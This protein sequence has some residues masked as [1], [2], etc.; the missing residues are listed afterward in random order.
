MAGAGAASTAPVR[1]VDPNG[2]PILH[3]GDLVTITFQDLVIPLAPIETQVKDDGTI[4]LIYNQQF[5]AEGKT[6]GQLEKEIYKT[7]VPAYFK[8][9]TPIVKTADHFF[10]VGGE[11]KSPGRQVYSG[12]MTVLGA[13]DTAGGFTDFAWKSH[14]VITRA[15]KKQEKVNASKALD[16]PELN[17][18]IFPGDQVF[19]R[20]RIL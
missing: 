18:E 16:H 17:V 20:K 8:N 5:Q 6:A 3:I 2:S 14:I 13:I 7:Y 9:L 1:I 4:T 19:V 11:V 15:G 10:T 12:R